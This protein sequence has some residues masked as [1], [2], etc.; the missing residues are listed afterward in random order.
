MQI[1][2]GVELTR[3]QLQGL[4]ER[5][6][7]VKL[8]PLDESPAPD[9]L[10]DLEV[11]F[12]NPPA[13]C[14]SEAKSLRWLQLE[15]VGFGEY[16]GLDWAHLGKRL[17]VTNLAGFFSD[18]VA[19]TALSG[20]LALARGID[21]LAVLKDAGTWVG[22]PLRSELR[23]LRNARIVMIGFG[24]I[25]RR[26]AELLRPFGCEIKVFRGDM[27]LPDLD[28]ALPD[29]DI[30]VCCVPDTPGTRGLFNAARLGLLP[31]HSVVANLGRGSLVNEDALANALKSG[32]IAGAVLDVTKD[33]PLPPDH[34]FWTCPNT[35]LTQHTGGGTAD[36]LDR[37]IDVFL[38]NLARYRA[39]QTL[40]GIVDFEKGY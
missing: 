30:V 26:L 32:A 28:H 18:P 13:A 14:L 4:Q 34:P 15:S 5:A 21:R 35:L 17:K 33:E 40:Q 23:L 8:E 6:G 3:L 10:T 12:G 19:E 22:D 16:T 25:N 24:A 36:E 2:I 11:I 31:R 38:D 27:R 7:S 37:K 9:A 20:L 39:G 1:G 29:A